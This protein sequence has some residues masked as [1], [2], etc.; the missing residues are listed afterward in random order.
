MVTDAAWQAKA[1][2]LLKAEIARVGLGYRDLVARLDAIGV[3]ESEQNI[4][5]KLSRGGFS[6]VFMLQVLTA[7]GCK[8]V[9]VSED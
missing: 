5:N 9:S 6:A 7:I 3:K 4:A 1:R 8:K 2:N